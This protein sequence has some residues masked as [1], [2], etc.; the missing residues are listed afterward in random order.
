MGR[1]ADVQDRLSPEVAFCDLVVHDA[2]LGRVVF[3]WGL[4][5]TDRRLFGV[6][7]NSSLCD[8]ENELG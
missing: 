1:L 4:L 2:L 8:L 6:L 3:R 7:S 5:I